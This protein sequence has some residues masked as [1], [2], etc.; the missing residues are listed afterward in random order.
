MIASNV[1]GD[2]ARHCHALHFTVRIGKIAC[3]IAEIKQNPLNLLSLMIR[4]RQSCYRQLQMAAP[5]R[6]HAIFDKSGTQINTNTNFVSTIAKY[7]K[8][9]ISFNHRRAALGICID[10][11]GASNSFG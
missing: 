4:S 11:V 6:E 7:L 1:I 2:I 5:R 10:S 9:Q 8:C 3:C